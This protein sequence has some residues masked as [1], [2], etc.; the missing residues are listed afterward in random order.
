MT[1]TTGSESEWSSS[2]S[3]ESSVLRGSGGAKKRTLPRVLD[4][5]IELIQWIGEQLAVTTEQLALLHGGHEVNV[6]KWRYK[7][8]RAGLMESQVVFQH[9]PAYVWLTRRGTHHAGLSR[10]TE[11][12]MAKLRHIEAQSWVRLY[13][14]D[15]GWSWIGERELARERGEAMAAA[16]DKPDRMK[17]A[18]SHRPDGV[19]V[20]PDGAEVAVEIER[21]PKA[22]NR[23]RQIASDAL[24]L[25][26][27]FD[28]YG[29]RRFAGLW[30]FAAPDVKEAV[31]RALDEPDAWWFDK[32]TV[33]DLP[34][35]ESFRPENEED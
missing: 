29:N 35:A 10:Y 30:F 2:K 27:G 28:K 16:G 21:T 11:P 15:F 25:R 23:I 1:S 26:E 12:A 7:F 19:V 17:I 6:R 5:D 18:T 14:E 9:Y 22:K 4:R 31:K 3:S 24:D 33:Y 32:V 34:D 13:I 20:Q 8:E